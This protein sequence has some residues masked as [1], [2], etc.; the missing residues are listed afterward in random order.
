MMFQ[1]R[2]LPIKFRA[3]QLFC[4]SFFKSLYIFVLKCVYF[5]QTNKDSLKVH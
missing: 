4:K 2:A 3:E 1:F 5:I